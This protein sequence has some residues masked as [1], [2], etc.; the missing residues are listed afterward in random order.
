MLAAEKRKAR[1]KACAPS[2]PD[3][4]FS[5]ALP[6]RNYGLTA[7]LRQINGVRVQS[8]WFGGE[9]NWTDVRRGLLVFVRSRHPPMASRRL[10]GLRS[11]QCSST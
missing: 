7:R 2:R 10:F 11:V 8:C 1:T 9:I 6:G 5:T 3:D 4:Q